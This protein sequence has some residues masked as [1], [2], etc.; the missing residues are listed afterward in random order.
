METD[1]FDIVTGELQGDTLAPYLFIICL[2]N[3]FRMS[4]DL[5]KENNFKPAKERSRR[6]PTKTITD[7]DYANDIALIANTSTQAKSWLHSLEWAAGGTGFHINTNK[8]EYMC[9]NQRGDIST[10]KGGP[11]KLE[12]NFTNLGSS[13]S[14]NENDIN[15]Q[16]AKAWTV[17][18]RLMVIWKSDPTDKIKWSFFQEAVMSI[19]LYGCTTWTLSKRMEKTIQVRRTRCAGD[20]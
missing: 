8:T 17:I 15:T 11:L 13:I 6:N 5:M 3:M 7:M 19:L 16:L 18:D 14:S 2:D 12:D 1:Y 9:F 10:L 4:I 20:C